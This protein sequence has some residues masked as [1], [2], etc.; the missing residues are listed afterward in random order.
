MPPREACKHRPVRKQIAVTPS[1][2]KLYAVSC[3]LCGRL[4]EDR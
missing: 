3:D 2:K 4:L 1:G